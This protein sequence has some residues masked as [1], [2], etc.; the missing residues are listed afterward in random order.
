MKRIEQMSL[1]ECHKALREIINHVYSA[2]YHRGH[3][4]TV[5]GNYVHVLPVETDSYFD[6]DTM[7]FWKPISDRLEELNRWISVDERWPEV[8]DVREKVLV[9]SAC[10]RYWKGIDGPHTNHKEGEV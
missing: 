6:D 1:S 9:Y 5:D 8:E 7:E 2:A 4:D 10:G 3:E